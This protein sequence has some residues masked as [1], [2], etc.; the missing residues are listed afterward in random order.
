MEDNA[1]ATVAEGISATLGDP[2]EYT[3]AEKAAIVIKYVRNFRECIPFIVSLKED[4][5]TGERD[6]LNR[7]REPIQDCHSWKE[8]CDLH[9]GKSDRRIRQV[10]AAAKPKSLPAVIPATDADVA[11]YE[12]EHPAVRQFTQ[13]L[14]TQMPP[15]DAASVLVNAFEKD[16]PPMSQQMAEAIVRIVVA[17]NAALQP[18]KNPALAAIVNRDAKAKELTN[19][20]G[21]EVQPDTGKLFNL[22]HITEEQI[23]AIADSG[24]LKDYEYVEPV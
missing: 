21:A 4:F 5:D 1:L 18:L 10:L 8:F 19:W 15:D 17:E 12:Q 23:L 13:K 24:C 20:L 2:A 11:E 6:S 14:L 3:S 22:L 9:L 16:K 7:L